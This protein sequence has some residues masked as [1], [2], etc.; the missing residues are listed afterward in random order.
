MGV[1]EADAADQL[2]FDG[3]AVSADAERQVEIIFYVGSVFDRIGA[4][5]GVGVVIALLVLAILVGEKGIVFER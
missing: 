3:G 5:G 4:V 1:S 2:V